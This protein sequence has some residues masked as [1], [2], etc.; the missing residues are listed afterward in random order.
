MSDEAIRVGPAIATQSYLNVEAI[1]DAISV[2][3]AQ[4]VSHKLGTILFTNKGNGGW[5]V[6]G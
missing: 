3:G 5:K 6:I 4:A 1:L 2:T